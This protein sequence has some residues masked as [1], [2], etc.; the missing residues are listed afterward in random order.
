MGMRGVLAGIASIF[1][2]CVGGTRVYALQQAQQVQAPRQTAPQALPPL[3]VAPRLVESPSTWTLSY[4][5]QQIPVGA[6][7]ARP[8][9]PGHPGPGDEGCPPLS[10][11]AEAPRI[12][13]DDYIDMQRVRCSPQ[14]AS[15]PLYT[16]RIYGDGRLVWHGEKDVSSMGNATSSVDAGE[17]Q[18]ILAKA[19]KWG[20]GSACDDYVG[21]AENGPASVMT[22]KIGGR[23]KTVHEVEPSNAPA[24]LYW[25]RRRIDLLD[26]VEY[27]LQWSN[28]PN[29]WMLTPA[30]EATQVDTVSPAERA[31]RSASYLPAYQVLFNGPGIVDYNY[32]LPDVGTTEEDRKNTWVVGTFESYR[33]YSIDS[34]DD[35]L[36]TEINFKIDSVVH[37]AEGSTVKAG[38][39][40]DVYDRGGKLRTADNV[41]HRC[42]V[43]PER[44]SFAPGRTYLLE[45]R[46][47]T[48]GSFY[49]AGWDVT[50][51][52]VEVSSV[53]DAV[54]A[55]E[56]KSE[57]V[58]KSLADAVAYV[59]GKL[60]AP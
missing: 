42:E 18:A 55:E 7:Q 37:G 52:V 13:A 27:L 4:P 51:G 1:A 58:G 33:V 31:V 11:F 49:A 41:V 29:R 54:K 26:A 9:N 6:P 20:F 45:L 24:G 2:L 10:V 15:C 32:G 8:N 19:L 38:A 47:G 16:V 46:P 48:G 56:G 36:Y 30:E 21:R 59:K 17:A 23:V 50:G 34:S 22:L 12:A 60:S 53:V 14:F 39:I 28:A 43:W 57:L 5:R 3:L 35:R 25:L 40:V 44:Y